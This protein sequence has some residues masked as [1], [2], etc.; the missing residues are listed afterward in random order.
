MDELPQVLPAA[1]TPV[2]LHPAQL[3]HLKRVAASRAK[4]EKANAKMRKNHARGIDK[5]LQRA[6]TRFLG[7]G[8]TLDAPRV[9]DLVRWPY[10]ESLKVIRDVPQVLRDAI[11]DDDAL[12][13]WCRETPSTTIDHVHP[14]N[15]GGS[16]HPLNLVG[17]CGLCNYIKSDFLPAELGWRL[18]LP[19][20]AFALGAE[21]LEAPC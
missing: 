20:R 7:P 18:R 5:A 11:L 17:A 10:V 4:L 2:K 16:N 6:A 1:G 3:A 13:V 12:C 14:L 15:R 19:Q 21:C 9:L 8:E